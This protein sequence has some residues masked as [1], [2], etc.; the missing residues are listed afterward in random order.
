M[1]DP[2]LMHALH[3]LADYPVLA[4]LARSSGTNRVLKNVKNLKKSVIPAQA[5]IQKS[6]ILL[7]TSHWTPAFAGVTACFSTP[8]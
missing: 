5:G 4:E 2:D 1:N 3:R 6:L 7:T 8:C